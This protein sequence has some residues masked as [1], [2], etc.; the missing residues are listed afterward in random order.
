MRA[1]FQIGWLKEEIECFANRQMSEYLITLEQKKKNAFF[2]AQPKVLRD[3]VWGNIH[4]S[5]SEVVILD[6]PIIQRLRNIGNLGLASLIFPGA[7]HSRFEHTLG[8]TY[9]SGKMANA[10][11]QKDPLHPQGHTLPIDVVSLIRLA[12]LFHDTGHIF[13]SH[14]GEKYFSS[15]H[16]S[17]SKKI[18]LAKSQVAKSLQLDSIDLGE[19]LSACIITSNPI[20]QLLQIAF[21][22]KDTG[23]ATKIAN[24]C[25]E[26]IL[27]FSSRPELTLYA[28]IING[29]IDADK[30]DYLAR[31]ALQTG[32]PVLFDLERLIEKMVPVTLPDN[33]A[34]NRAKNPIFYL[35]IQQSGVA[36]VEELTL[37][38]R[39][40]YEKVYY[41]HKVQTAETMLSEALRL[42][43]I[44]AP[45]FFSRFDHVLRLSDHDLIHW[46]ASDTLLDWANRLGTSIKNETLFSQATLL[47]ERLSKRQLFYREI[48]LYHYNQEIINTLSLWCPDY[49][50]H[51]VCYIATL[52]KI[53]LQS[54][55]SILM[56]KNIKITQTVPDIWVSHHH[57]VSHYQNQADTQ[58]LPKEK[59]VWIICPEHI[60]TYVIL[61]CEKKLWQDKGIMLEKNAWLYLKA[62][63][64][65]VANVKITLTEKGYYTDTPALI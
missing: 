36:S 64:E 45:D 42:I 9:I 4:L 46:E 21:D 31:D 32:V 26:L 8:V 6:S 7:T 59:P 65:T 43:E 40:M 3:A 27:G 48:E 57:E 13:Y 63:E 11:K 15:P 18:S 39:F 17:R 28:P 62:S 20:I 38:R 22:L 24:C 1:I 54:P 12:A 47:L 60:V 23:E 19:L 34:S 25:A 29:P 10:I 35:G 2:P 49:L 30:C 61:A 33:A 52:L 44:S 50:A 41:H 58:Y 14:T 53:P 5:G 51:E 37:S 55:V 16:Y 56:T